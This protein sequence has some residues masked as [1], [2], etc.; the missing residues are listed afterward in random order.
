MCDLAPSLE[1]IL[2]GARLSVAIQ[3]LLTSVSK[4]VNITSQT[5][6][7]ELASHDN[8]I[9]RV[10]TFNIAIQSAALQWPLWIKTNF[11]LVMLVLYVLKQLVC[12][13]LHG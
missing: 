10:H 6:Y 2:N 9:Q 12:H 5:K 3:L 13:T 11:R 7:G 8:F 4:L 1:A